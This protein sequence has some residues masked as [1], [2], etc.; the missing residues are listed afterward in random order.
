MDTAII[1]PAEEKKSICVSLIY[2]YPSIG[3]IRVAGT[4]SGTPLRIN[5]I[6]LDGSVVLSGVTLNS[7]VT[8]K[9]VTEART[10][11]VQVDATSG[12]LQLI[13]ALAGASVEIPMLRFMTGVWPEATGY[14]SVIT[15]Y[16]SISYNLRWGMV[17]TVPENNCVVKCTRLGNLVNIVSP[18][19]LAVTPAGTTATVAI[20][21]SWIPWRFCPFPQSIYQP[22]TVVLSGNHYVGTLYIPHQEADSGGWCAGRTYVYPTADGSSLVWPSSVQCGI[23][24]EV[25]YVHAPTTSYI[26]FW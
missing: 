2:P 15:G 26:R 21:S 13:P 17:W 6:S 5:T 3:S 16:E 18:M 11:T 20:L 12:N 14:Q 1:L 19:A 24:F 23:R 9:D 8:L 25:T 4:L 22:C 7:P 10:A